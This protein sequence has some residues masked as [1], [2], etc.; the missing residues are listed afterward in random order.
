M[1]YEEQ[2]ND[3]RWKA[4]REQIIEKYWG[5]CVMCGTSK[6]IHVH[7][8]KYIK[9]L[10]AWEYPDHL[11]IPLCK[12]CHALEHN[13][14]PTDGIRTIKSVLIEFINSIRNG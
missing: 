1:T 5:Y 7:H 2:L 9:G 12:D 4:R 3:D 10:M 14:V 13:K 11:L 8:K 6:N